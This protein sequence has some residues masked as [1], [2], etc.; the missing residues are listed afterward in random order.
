MKLRRAGFTILELLV[1]ISI[2][3]LLMSILMPGLRSAREQAKRVA[4]QSNLKNV[5]TALLTYVSEYDSYPVLFR[6]NP[7][8]CNAVSWAT[9]SFGGWTGRDFETYCDSGGNGTHCYHTDQR[10]LSVYLFE[11]N[12]ILPDHKGADNVFGSGDDVVTETPIFRCPSDESSTQ[13]KWRGNSA[14]ANVRDM[15]AYDQCGS[16]Y[17]MNY[18]WFFQALDRV[19]VEAGRCRNLRKWNK[20]FEIGRRLWRSADEQKGAVRFVTLV[21]DPFDWGIAQDLKEAANA[22]AG[23]DYRHHVTGEQTMGFHGKWS[24]HM[25]AFL[26]G[27]VDYLL[28]DTRYQREVRWTVTNERWND[29]RRRENCPPFNLSSPRDPP[30]H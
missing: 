14:G 5:N 6:V 30:D 29:T 8:N 27:H 20:A 12:S 18:Y 11:P 7:N 13:W 4:C 25:M 1:V 15:S 10:P 19:D 9:W 24:R 21:E 16:S 2:I 28:A 17:Q 22:E 26:D 23:S 3:A